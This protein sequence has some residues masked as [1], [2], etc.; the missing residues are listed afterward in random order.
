[1]EQLVQFDWYAN[2]KIFNVSWNFQEFLMKN[3]P[4]QASAFSKSKTPL[5]TL[6]FTTIQSIEVTPYSIIK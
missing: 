2:L 6:Q 1:M 4:T 3:Q 5:Q